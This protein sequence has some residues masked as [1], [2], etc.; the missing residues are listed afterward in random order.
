MIDFAQ[1]TPNEP[2]GWREKFTSIA[3]GKDHLLALTSTGRTF[4]HPVTKQANSYGQLGFQKFAVPDP[5][6][7]IIGSPGSHLHI[8]LTPKSISDPNWKASRSMRVVS[9]NEKLGDEDLAAIN[10]KCIRFCPF[11]YEI[12]ALRGVPVEQIAAGA[13]TSFVRTPSGRVLGWGANEFGQLGLG[14]KVTMDTITIPTEVILWRAVS[15]DLDTNCTDMAAGESLSIF[16]WEMLT[17]MLV[18][19]GDL[20]AFVVDRSDKRDVSY[21]ELL[22]SGNG[23]WGGLGNNVMTT[24][25]SN[26]SRVKAVSGMQQCMYLTLSSCLPML[27]L[28]LSQSVKRPNASNRS[29]S[30]ASPFRLRATSSSPST[31]LP[32]PTVSAGMTYTSGVA[33][34]TVNLGTGRSPASRSLSLCRW[35]RPREVKARWIQ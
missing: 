6:A 7:G 10:D 2:F 8:T 29:G 13:R 11:I 30:P 35:I 16:V 19:A 15:R 34:S 18:I 22:M 12:P 4:A 26:A 9:D 31:H 25:Q 21:S 33:I 24:A 5:T 17:S 14:D 3:A 1:L 32:T 27:K 20:A 23:Q 28:P